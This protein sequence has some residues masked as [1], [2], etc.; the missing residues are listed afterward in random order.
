[1][2]ARTKKYHKKVVQFSGKKLTLYSLDGNTW[3]TRKTELED[4]IERHEQERLKLASQTGKGKKPVPAAGKDSK[5]NTQEKKQASNIKPEEPK[6]TTKAKTA[7]KSR[8]KTKAKAKSKP[9]ATPK[10]RKSTAPK[11]KAKAK[12]K[13]KRA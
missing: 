2:A 11:K 7:A 1:M 10:T 5:E 12:S 13:K 6:K 9:K 4:I 3:S 8:T